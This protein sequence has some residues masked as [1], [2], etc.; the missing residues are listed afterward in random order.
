MKN[1]I[2]INLLTKLLKTPEFIKNQYK[3][4]AVSVLY[5]IHHNIKKI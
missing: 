2:I 1:F 4:N 3:R 5:N